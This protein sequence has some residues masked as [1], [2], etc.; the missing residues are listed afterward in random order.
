MENG[1]KT[2]AAVIEIIFSGF[3]LNML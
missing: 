2:I 3:C 1:V